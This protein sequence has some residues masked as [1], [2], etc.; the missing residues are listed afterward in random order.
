[1]VLMLNLKFEIRGYQ[2]RQY[3]TDSGASKK[4]RSAVE[5]ICLD[6]AG[7]N[8]ANRTP[9]Q[10]TICNGNESQEWTIN[11][12]DRTIRALGKCLDVSNASTENGAIVQI[13]ECNGSGAQKWIVSMTHEIVSLSAW[14][15]LAIRTPAQEGAQ[16]QIE[17][18]DG[19]ANQK[20][21]LE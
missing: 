20:W 13:F 2:D 19:S 18:C 9:V 7:G 8:S 12:K 3:Y 11:D 4:I 16:T 5:G 17:D 15:C 1:M 6:V 14:K 21:S 10:V